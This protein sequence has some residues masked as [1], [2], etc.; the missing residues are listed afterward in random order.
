M[1]VSSGH[2]AMKRGCGTLVCASAR[3]TRASRRITSLLAGRKCGGPRRRTYARPPRVNFSITFCVP[4]ARASTPATGP[5][6]RP[7][8]SI[9][10]ASTSKST[11]PRPTPDCCCALASATGAASRYD[12]LRPG[13][14]A[15]CVGREVE[16]GADD[17]FRLAAAPEQDAL[18]R[19][20][21][22]RLHV[23]RLRDIGQERAGDDA[24]DAHLRGE[25]AGEAD[26][27][28][29]DAGLRR[30]VRDDVRARAERRRARDEDDRPAG[31]CRHARADDRREP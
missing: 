6:G 13:D 1:T 30:A 10:A 26:G 16:G 5:P 27:H 18:L 31:A 29:V 15:R 24:V 8:A 7:C 14:E 28:V 3:R 11:T 23:P 2:A 4:P 22:E 20:P 12:E 17:L 9:H 25:G 21:P 19:R